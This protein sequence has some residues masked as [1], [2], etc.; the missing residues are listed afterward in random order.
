M[1]ARVDGR[2]EFLL[3]AGAMALAAGE[4]QAETLAAVPETKPRYHIRFA[5]CGISHDHIH[6][7]IGA[8]QRGGGELVSW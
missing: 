5:V 4:A 1:E 2:R 7:M 8:V 3:A 6:A